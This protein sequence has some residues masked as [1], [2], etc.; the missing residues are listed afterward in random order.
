MFRWETA[1]RLWQ[2]AHSKGS[3]ENAFVF[4][5]SSHSFLGEISSHTIVPEY[6]HMWASYFVGENKQVGW[7]PVP[8]WSKW[9]LSSVLS[10][11]YMHS[12]NSHVDWTVL[13][14]IRRPYSTSFPN[15]CSFS[16]CRFLPLRLGKTVIDMVSV[17]IIDLVIIPCPLEV[18][19]AN[20]QGQRR[21]PLSVTYG[22][23]DC[24]G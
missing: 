7:F 22:W 19:T 21:R 15:F 12:D 23:L 1:P 17:L 2:A 20:N 16:S 24:A 3:R 4:G 6:L 14:Q 5:S 8:T 9:P 13:N 11:P 18:E 10:I